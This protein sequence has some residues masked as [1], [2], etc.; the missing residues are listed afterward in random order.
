MNMWNAS[1]NFAQ[2]SAHACACHL[3]SAQTVT[4]A[5]YQPQ[6]YHT[7]TLQ[8][9]SLKQYALLR[10]PPACAS[11]LRLRKVATKANS[12][13][14][15]FQPSRQCVYAHLSTYSTGTCFTLGPP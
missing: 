14:I 9:T 1:T 3:H 6:H 8:E 10:N 2:P 15:P 12:P 5:C 13:G 7:G 11:T 4:E